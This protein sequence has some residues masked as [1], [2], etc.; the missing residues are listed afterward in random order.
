LE[1]GDWGLRLAI[2]GLAIA[3]TAISHVQS[4]KI[5]SS[6]WCRSWN[7]LRDRHAA[8]QLTRASSSVAAN[9]RACC[10]ARSHT[11]FTSKIGLVAEEADESLGWLEHLRDCAFVDRDA[12]APLLQEARELTKI[13]GGSYATARKREEAAR[14]F[15]RPR[16]PQPR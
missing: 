14:P 10:R 13:L 6:S 7:A 8:D 16:P 12:V 2:G 9:Y 1:I 3:A 5:A 4:R 15:R 11:E